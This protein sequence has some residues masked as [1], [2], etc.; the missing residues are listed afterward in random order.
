MTKVDFSALDNMVVR[1]QGIYGSR[2]E[3]VRFLEDKGAVEPSV[4]VP[5][6][7]NLYV[8]LTSA[9]HQGISPQELSR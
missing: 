1:P 9:I 4:C 8:L 5:H 7:V 6:T 3:I 2:S